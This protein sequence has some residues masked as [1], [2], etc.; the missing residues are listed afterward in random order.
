MTEALQRIRLLAKYYYDDLRWSDVREHE[1]RTFL[2]I[3]LLLALGWAEQQLK[4]ELPVKGGRVD[5]ACYDGPFSREKSEDAV[6]L[7]ETKGFSSGLDYAPQQAHE[8]AT[9][10][11]NCNL[12][13][14]TN[15]YCYKTYARKNDETFES[16]QPA[17]Y[18]NLLR[19]RDR[20]PLDPETTDGA[21]EVL[22][23]LLPLNNRFAPIG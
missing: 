4:I 21:L 10:F 15:G 9:H 13:I 20:Y 22:R 5:I 3:P 11:R 18:L 23:C 7:I 16:K 6:A 19:P 1:T 17:A 14:V 8:Y 2:V 12:V